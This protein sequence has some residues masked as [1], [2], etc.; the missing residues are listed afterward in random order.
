MR[1]SEKAHTISNR[2]AICDPGFESQIAIAIK[3]C[4]LEQLGHELLRNPPWG[5]PCHTKKVRILAA[6]LLSEA[7]FPP[8]REKGADEE[9]GKKG[10]RPEKQGS[11]RKNQV[12]R[13]LFS[14]GTTL[15]RL[16]RI[17]G[18]YFQEL[19]MKN[20]ATKLPF[21]RLFDSVFSEGF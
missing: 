4:D 20:N 6:H 3:S 8:P 15:S 1:F 16:Q 2:F 7:P 17:F 19:T 18:G 11:R 13:N 9:S 10:D 21:F 5:R 12:K 14:S